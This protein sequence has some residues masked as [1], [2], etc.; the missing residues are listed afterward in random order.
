MT[1]AVSLAVAAKR[2]V[3]LTMA[4]H[5]VLFLLLLPFFAIEVSSFVSISLQQPCERFHQS[6][7]G[8]CLLTKKS[9][10]DDSYLSGCN[11]SEFGTDIR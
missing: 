3:P 7:H 11:C 4:L 1:R 5:H 6:F 8:H 2:A 10:D 9:K